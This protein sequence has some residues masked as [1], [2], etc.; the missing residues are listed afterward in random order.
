MKNKHHISI[1]LV[2]T[3]PVL[4]ETVLPNWI[5]C[6]GVLYDNRIRTK[7]RTLGQIKTALTMALRGTDVVESF[8]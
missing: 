4:T 7:T 6:K 5:Q 8:D 1:V 3:P 2:V